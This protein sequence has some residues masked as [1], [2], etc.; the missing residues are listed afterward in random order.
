MADGMKE[1]GGDARAEPP[2]AAT[3]EANCH[4]AVII[5][6]ISHVLFNDSQRGDVMSIREAESFYRRLVDWRQTLPEVLT[7]PASMKYHYV[8]TLL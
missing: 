8:A 5:D 1:R 2:I 3:F 7:K 6:E 4:L